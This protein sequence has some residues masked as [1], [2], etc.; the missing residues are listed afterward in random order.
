MNAL[1]QAME[2][3]RSRTNDI[4]ASVDSAEAEI[5]AAMQ[6]HPDQSDWLYGTFLSLRPFFPFCSDML[7]RV[8]CQEILERVA[9]GQDVTPPTR[10]EM[11]ELLQ[12]VTAFVP[13]HSH[14]GALY[15]RLFDE[16]FPG[17]L[18]DE[19]HVLNERFPGETDPLR[20]EVADELFK[21]T[22]KREPP[23]MDTRWREQADMPAPEQLSLFK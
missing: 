4:F 5:K 20:Q 23:R 22:V 16:L 13:F 17:K 1:A 21:I 2:D 8:H 19:V 3:I 9:S 10:A 7:Y 14:A 6:R 15:Q 12:R 18:E 11:I